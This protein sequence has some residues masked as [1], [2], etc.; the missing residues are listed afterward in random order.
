[1]DEFV[2]INTANLII[3]SKKS[4]TIFFASMA[5]LLSKH[6]SVSLVKGKWNGLDKRNRRMLYS[7]CR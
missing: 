3:Q 6:P 1:M 2:L 4:M 5:H 7:W